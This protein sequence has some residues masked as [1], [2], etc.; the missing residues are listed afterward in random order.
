MYKTHPYMHNILKNTHTHTHTHTH[1]QHTHTHT[2]DCGDYEFKCVS[3]NIVCINNALVCN[4]IDNCVDGS[5]EQF[6][7]RRTPPGD[8]EW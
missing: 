4:G 2:G 6:C 7:G 8:G 3:G 1:T 5:D